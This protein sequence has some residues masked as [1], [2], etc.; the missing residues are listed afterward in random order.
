[1]NEPLKRTLN[2]FRPCDFFVAE[3]A[4]TL[5]KPVTMTAKTWHF[6]KPA[7]SARP[8][9]ASTAVDGRPRRPVINRTTIP[10]RGGG[11]AEGR[12]DSK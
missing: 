6:G 5:M 1:M 8:A 12:N 3:Q 10:R 11:Q 9:L 7:L 4:F 2:R